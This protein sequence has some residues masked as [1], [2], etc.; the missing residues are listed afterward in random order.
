MH[1]GLP[2]TH[3]YVHPAARDVRM[4][5]TDTLSSL[6][7]TPAPTTPSPALPRTARSSPA[8]PF[9]SRHL[10]LATITH[11]SR[12][13]PHEPYFNNHPTPPRRPTSP[14]PQQQ[15]RPTSPTPLPRFA[16]GD[17]HE[18]KYEYG[19]R[20]G[21]GCYIWTNGDMFRGVWVKGVITGRG[22]KTT[23]GGDTYT[24]QWAKDKVRGGRRKEV[25]Y[26]PV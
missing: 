12:H 16:N 21:F 8:P 3:H 7:G 14:T 24:G 2:S 5:L 9:V 22:T 6:A 26:K 17:R 19:R 23:T 13:P 4:V 15:P 20:S 25:M 1:L 10:S 18:G 11:P